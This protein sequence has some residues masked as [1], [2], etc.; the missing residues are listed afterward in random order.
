[1]EVK[2]K[3]MLDYK[4]SHY[5]VRALKSSSVRLPSKGIH[6]FKRRQD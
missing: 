5:I 6:I 2:R 4:N 3:V 1:M